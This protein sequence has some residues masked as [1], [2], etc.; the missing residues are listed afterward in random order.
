[1]TVILLVTATETLICRI[2]CGCIE[3]KVVIPGDDNFMLVWQFLEKSI[4][5]NYIAT[6]ADN[7]K[8]SRMD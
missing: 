2:K 8:I 1:M 7:R 6:L 3:R 5:R 4:K